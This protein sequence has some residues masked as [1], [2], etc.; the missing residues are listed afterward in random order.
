M[1][2]GTWEMACWQMSHCKHLLENI[3]SLVMS[4]Y[5]WTS[6]TICL[7]KNGDKI[8]LKNL[9]PVPQKWREI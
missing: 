4:I 2:N 5:G 6:S 3:F 9:K 8:R 1:A 7:G